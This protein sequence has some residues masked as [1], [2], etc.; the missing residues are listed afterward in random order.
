M[1]WHAAPRLHGDQ[2]GLENA[3]RGEGAEHDGPRSFSQSHEGDYPDDRDQRES[4]RQTERRRLAPG[5]RTLPRPTTRE[6]DSEV[7][8]TTGEKKNACQIADPLDSLAHIVLGMVTVCDL[9]YT[10]QL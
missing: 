7:Q 8:E 3:C 2:R 6:K 1:G 10:R 5:E 4:E 9:R